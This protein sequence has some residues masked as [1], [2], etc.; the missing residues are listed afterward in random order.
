MS[1]NLSSKNWYEVYNILKEHSA[2]GKPLDF[3]IASFSHLTFDGV[4]ILLDG[5]Y[6]DLEEKQNYAP[7]V[8][9]FIEFVRKNELQ[10][11]V[12]FHGYIVGKDRYDMRI[13]FEGIEGKEEITE[14]TREQKEELKKLSRTA[15]SLPLRFVG[16]VCEGL[17]I[18]WD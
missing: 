8:G 16:N 15:D 11:K 12:D 6:L 9:E 1:S 5:G 17:Y 4:Q 7:T 3:D 14:V 13:S 18:W 10:D 2:I